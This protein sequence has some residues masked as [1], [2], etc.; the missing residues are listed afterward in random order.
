MDDALYLRDDALDTVLRMIKFHY[1]TDYSELDDDKNLEEEQEYAPTLGYLNVED[2]LI[3][4][5]F[6]LHFGVFAIADKYEIP[7]LGDLAQ[8]KFEAAL[9]REHDLL[10]FDPKDLR[11]LP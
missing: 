10:G 9:C 2:K 7:T 3:Q 8:Q 6:L 4:R 11:C 1:R 5:R